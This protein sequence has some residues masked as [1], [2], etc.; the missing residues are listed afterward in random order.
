[1]TRLE[2][3]YKHKLHPLKLDLQ[4]IGCKADE[5]EHHQNV[6]PS[7]VSYHHITIPYLLAKEEKKAIQLED[8]ENH[9]CSN[10]I[11]MQGVPEGVPDK[12][13]DSTLQQIFVSL[14]KS[15]KH[16]SIELDRVYRTIDHV[17]HQAMTLDTEYAESNTTNKMK[18]L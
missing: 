15:P 9:I 12:E 5:T 10:N 6:L 17:Q 18:L 14:L 2:D 11:G 4:D 3:A 13:L 1:M 8:I 16:S 7:W